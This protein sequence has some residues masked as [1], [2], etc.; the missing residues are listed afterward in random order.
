MK[1]IF[2]ALLLVLSISLSA[3]EGDF[4]ESIQK[5]RSPLVAA[6]LSLGVSG[7]GHFYLGENG[8]GAAHLAI[9]GVSLLMITSN[10][11]DSSARSGNLGLVVIGVAGLLINKVFSFASAIDIAERRKKAASSLSLAPL[12]DHSKDGPSAGIGL[13]LTF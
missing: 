7:A 5:V 1:Y 3:Q 13:S 2:S 12:F 11:H 9:T 8:Q 4:D 10:S 6:V